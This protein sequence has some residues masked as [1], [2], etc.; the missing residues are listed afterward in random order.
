MR[1]FSPWICRKVPPETVAMHGINETEIAVLPKPFL[2]DRIV[3]QV[4]EMLDA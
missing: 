3:K 4:R 1:L 2:Q